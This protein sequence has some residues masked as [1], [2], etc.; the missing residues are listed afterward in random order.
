M[1]VVSGTHEVVGMILKEQLELR[2][3]QMEL[4]KG[5]VEMKAL[6]NVR[7]EEQSKHNIRVEDILIQIINGL[8]DQ[9]AT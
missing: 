6:Q 1:K 5:L 8:P 2:K 4:R 7:Y 9:P 3:E